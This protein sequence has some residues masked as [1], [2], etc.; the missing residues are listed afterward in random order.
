MST[1]NTTTE[2]PNTLQSNSF[3]MAVSKLPSLSPFVNGVSLPGMVMGEVQL[4]TPFADRRV[5]GDKLIFAVL[6][7]S[8]LVDEDMQNWMECYDWMTSLGYPESFAQ[9]GAIN[10]IAD[11]RSSLSGNDVYS[12]GTLITHNNSGKAIKK[13]E[14][15]DLFPIALGEIPLS[16]GDTAGDPIISTIDLQYTYYTVNSI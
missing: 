5:P 4:G 1:L 12:D 8:F 3:A 15:V 2:N 14:F 6:T 11:K 10:R 7:I 9:Y 13:V 16:T